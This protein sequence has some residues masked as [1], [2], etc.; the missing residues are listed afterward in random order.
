MRTTLIFFLLISGF[1][2]L[3]SAQDQ[4]ALRRSL[5]KRFA[6]VPDRGP[7]GEDSAAYCEALIKRTG[8]AALVRDRRNADY[9]LYPSVRIRSRV[10]RID[11]KKEVEVE[12]TD[13]AGK[14]T[15]K[16]ED[17]V[18][19]QDEVA[20]VTTTFSCPIEQPVKD[21]K[22]RE[23]AVIEGSISRSTKGT[24]SSGHRADD[25]PIR[26]RTYQVSRLERDLGSPEGNS[27]QPALYRT[28]F[29]LCNVMGKVLEIDLPNKRLKVSLGSDDGIQPK[30]DPDGVTEMEVYAQTG[31]KAIYCFL[32]PATGIVYVP[33]KKSVEAA[34][35]SPRDW[36]YKQDDALP[37]ERSRVLRG[38]PVD[39]LIALGERISS[40]AEV[41]EVTRDTCTITPKKKGDFGR[42]QDDDKA[43]SKVPDP[44]K[45][46]V[47]ARVR[48]K[49][50]FLHK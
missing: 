13:S 16:K 26:F 47:I 32:E 41:Q 9:I 11:H 2:N 17:R 14:K 20:I 22:P 34:P 27:G 29:G 46:T 37:N 12:K 31:I 45:M 10:T 6:V 39:V 36:A 40:W 38:P 3:G 50:G 33:D 44:D 25:E 35:N 1:P 30:D 48:A 7:E 42:T 43:F 19:H 4:A 24:D 21:E 8:V 18:F 15:K 23:V 28:I 49:H 5:Q